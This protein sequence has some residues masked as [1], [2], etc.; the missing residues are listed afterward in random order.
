MSDALRPALDTT[1]PAP[2]PGA[3]E[4]RART[5]RRALAAGFA[6]MFVAAALMWAQFGPTMFVDLATAVLN[7]F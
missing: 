5:A 4:A 1:D 7:C 3:E 2:Q 6:L